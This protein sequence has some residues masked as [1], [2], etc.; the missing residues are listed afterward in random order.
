M[1][2][3]IIFLKKQQ[4]EKFKSIRKAI[5]KKNTYRFNSIN[6]DQLLKNKK[7][8]NLKIISSFFSI[9]SE[10]STADLNEYLISKNKILSF[11]VVNPKSKILSFRKFKKNQKLVEG[12]Y[13][14]PEP[15]LENE[16]LIPNL[17]FVPCLAFDI[18]GYR[19]GYGGGYYDRTFA[20]FKSINHQFISV[21]F[22]YDDQKVDRV[23]KDQFDYKLNYVLTEKQLYTFV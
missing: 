23:I 8:N 11:P 4:R 7:L 16:E 9:K 15:L 14:I 3:D 1:M 10:I 12:S 22:A 20:H 6:I 19:L 18:Q 13:N 21:G 5:S 2:N 17:I